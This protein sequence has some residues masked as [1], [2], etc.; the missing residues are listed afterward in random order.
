MSYLVSNLIAFL[1]ALCAFIYGAV[2][3]FKPKKPL[4]FKMLIWS[5]GCY[6]LS[7][8]SGIVYLWC[9]MATEVW[10]WVFGI[11]GCE[12]FLLSANYGAFDSL[13]DDGSFLKARY[14]ALAAPLVIIMMMLVMAAV[15]WEDGISTVAI[16]AI[17]LGPS[18]PASYFSLKHLLLPMDDFG[19]L[20]GT[21]Q[22]DII[23]LAFLVL[24]LI[25]AVMMYYSSGPAT[26]ALEILISIILCLLTFEAIRGEKAW[27]T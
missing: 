16:F 21:R 13:V 22:C 23:Q 18:V 20:R 11:F 27:K 26:C 17:M 15:W 25:Y 4:Y 5:V 19:L 8:L 24:A 7:L 10:T 3:M 12:M 1:I 14:Q 6:A 9:H 2:R